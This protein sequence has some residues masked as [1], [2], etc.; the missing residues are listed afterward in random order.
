MALLAKTLLCAVCFFFFF[1]VTTIAAS[2]WFTLD[3]APLPF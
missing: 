3:S 1:Y 2:A